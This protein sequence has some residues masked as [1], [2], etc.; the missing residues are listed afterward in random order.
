MDCP[1]AS[2]EDAW[3]LQPKADVSTYGFS[4]SKVW[5]GVVSQMGPPDSH[6]LPVELVR[7]KDPGFTKSASPGGERKARE[8]LF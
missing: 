7:N 4:E 6:R 8:S 3:D 2:S 5:Q 1:G